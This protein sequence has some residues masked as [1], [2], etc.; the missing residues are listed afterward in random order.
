MRKSCDYE[1]PFKLVSNRRIWEAARMMPVDEV[2]TGGETL[3]NNG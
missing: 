1:L 2:Q 3:A